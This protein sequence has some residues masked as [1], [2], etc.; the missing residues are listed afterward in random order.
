MLYFNTE[1]LLLS[2]LYAFTFGVFLAGIYKSLYLIIAYLL[3]MLRLPFDALLATSAKTER[4]PTAPTR[5]AGRITRELF[6]LI[7]FSL[8]GAFYI[9]LI[10]VSLDG[11]PRIHFFILSLFGFILSRRSIAKLIGKIIDLTLSRI[12][13]ISFTALFLILTPIRLI[14]RGI[15][16]LFRPIIHRAKKIVSA[17]R[18]PSITRICA[19]AR[20]NKGKDDRRADCTL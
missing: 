12:Y 11:I 2:C 14:G 10:F 16:Y 13:K 3:K 6:D 1:E 18:Y 17:A 8:A 15:K 7:F 5:N 20:H 9:L 4:I 19:P